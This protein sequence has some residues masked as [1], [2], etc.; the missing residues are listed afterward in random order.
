MRVLD[1]V[2]Y[3]DATDKE[4]AE[5]EQQEQPQYVPTDAERIGALEEAIRKGMML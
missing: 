1:N 3:R 5:W 2:I 4:I